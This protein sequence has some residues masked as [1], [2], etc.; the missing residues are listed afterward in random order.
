M[1]YDDGWAFW[2]ALV[3]LVSVGVAII[4]YWRQRLVSKRRVLATLRAVRDGMIKWKAERGWGDRHFGT[5]YSEPEAETRARQD[6]DAIMEKTYAQNFR[7]PTEP[8]AALIQ[9]PDALI[10]S[11]TVEAVNIALWRIGVFNQLV[12]QQTDFNARHLAE[13]IHSNLPDERRRDL[14]EA[15][16]RISVMLHR[17]A[18]GDASWY[19]DLK[20]ALTANIETL[21]SRWWTKPGLCC[22]VIGGITLPIAVAALILAAI[23]G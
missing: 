10:T 4:I 11:G 18:I 21:E 16:R 20:A 22:L 5:A 13:I 12:Q 6:F 2:G 9:R 23:K 7:V 17:D 8:L 1:K 15:A 3:V 14:A 19:Q